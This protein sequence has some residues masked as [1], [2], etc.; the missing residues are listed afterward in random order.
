MASKF[1]TVIVQMGL[2]PHAE[3]N[4]VPSAFDLARNQEQRQIMELVLGTGQ[5]LRGYSAPPGVPAERLA[6]LREA[7]RKTVEDPDFINDMAQASALDVEYLTPAA[8]DSFMALPP[9]MG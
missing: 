9:L 2:K 8:I 7:F 5:F 6:A 3:L 1:V 4:D